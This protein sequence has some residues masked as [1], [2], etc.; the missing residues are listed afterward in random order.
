MLAD[1]CRKEL[2][3]RILPFWNKIR[4]DENGGFYGFM[5][6]DLQVDKTADKG[7]LLYPSPSPRD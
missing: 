1:K 7:C 2:T 5:D 3:E 6:T 4:D